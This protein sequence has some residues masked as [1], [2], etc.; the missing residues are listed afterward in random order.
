MTFLVVDKA[1]KVH[2]VEAATF[3]QAIDSV[4]DPVMAVLGKTGDAELDR[5]N[6]TRIGQEYDACTVPIRSVSRDVVSARVI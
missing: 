5:K 4:A 3:E 1:D 6:V 2:F